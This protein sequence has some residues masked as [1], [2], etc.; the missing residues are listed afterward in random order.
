MSISQCQYYV[1]MPNGEPKCT[2]LGVDR[3]TCKGNVQ[4]CENDK[5]RR[6]VELRWTY[7]NYLLWG[8]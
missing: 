5:L 4:E 8:G 7:D 2:L 6:E 1:T 3:P